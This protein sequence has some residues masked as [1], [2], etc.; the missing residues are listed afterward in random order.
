MFGIKS[1]N[2]LSKFVY[3]FLNRTEPNYFSNQCGSQKNRENREFILEHKD[4][5][6][7]M[8]NI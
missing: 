5:L 2:G 6:R 7:T 8:F 1:S 4:Q 3:R